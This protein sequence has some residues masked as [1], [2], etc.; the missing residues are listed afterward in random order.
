MSDWFTTNKL[1]LNLGKKY[2]SLKQHTTIWPKYIKESAN[3]K[4]LGLQIDNH[5]NWKYHID[6][7]VP[8]LSGTCYPIKSTFHVSN[9]DT[10]KSVYYLY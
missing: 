2:S 7:M 4:F 6:Q 9:T 1:A 5:L 10:L 3:M 8:K